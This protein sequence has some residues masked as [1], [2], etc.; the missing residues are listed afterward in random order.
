MQALKSRA[1][2]INENR[3]LK[4]QFNTFRKRSKTSKRVTFLS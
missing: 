3:Q 1:I 2:S 4:N